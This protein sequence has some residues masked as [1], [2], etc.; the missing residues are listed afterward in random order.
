MRR[1]R[2]GRVPED[3]SDRIIAWDESTRPRVTPPDDSTPEGMGRQLVMIHDMFR[4][5][6]DAICQVRDQVRDGRAGVGALRQQIQEL[7]LQEAF[8]R[9]GSH[10]AQ[11]CF[12]VNAHHSIEDVYM[13]PALRMAAGHLGP[14]LERLS[15]EHVTIH[16]VLVDLDRAAVTLA[17]T[18]EGF[19]LVDRLV[20]VLATGLR[21]HLAYEESQLVS[22]LSD[23]RIVI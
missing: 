4:H 9:L 2:I 3:L 8:A 7:T 23:H 11:Y 13:F 6:L 19:D 12:H 18:G 16:Q 21:S 22:P 5:E 17:R 14:V 1:G 20:D 15:E 10:C